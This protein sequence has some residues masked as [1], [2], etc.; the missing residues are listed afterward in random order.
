VSES[1]IEQL[2]QAIDERD[3]DAAMAPMA[4]ECRMLAVD[5]RRGEGEAGVR[6]LLTDF[7]ATVRATTHRITAQWHED[8]VWIAE[9]DVSYELGDRSKMSG[10]PRAMVL[11][12]GPRGVTEL[13]VYGAHERKLSEQGGGDGSMRIGGHWIPPL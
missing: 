7:V 6:A 13:H 4:P 1:P 3:V 11:R 12:E 9:V 2:L 10:V 5:G 8:D